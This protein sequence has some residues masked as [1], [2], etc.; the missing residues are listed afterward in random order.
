MHPRIIGSKA[1]EDR[2]TIFFRLKETKQLHRGGVTNEQ[3]SLIF[4]HPQMSPLLKLLRC[5]L[6]FPFF[7]LPCQSRLISLLCD[8]RKDTQ[9]QAFVF[10][11]TI[12]APF[13]TVDGPKTSR[14]LYKSA[15]ANRSR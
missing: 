5:Q 6:S 8:V 4:L 13:A 11:Y 10:V 9:Q 1:E 14:S 3:Q 12:V 7:V 2:A 15:V